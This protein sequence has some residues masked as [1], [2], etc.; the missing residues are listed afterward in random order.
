MRAVYA[1]FAT[2]EDGE[3]EEVKED[4]MEKENN[5]VVVRCPQSS[6]QS[7]SGRRGM[8]HTYY[9]LQYSTYLAILV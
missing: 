2:K 6:Q 1:T 3:L 9:I 4:S 8:L 5:V 7:R